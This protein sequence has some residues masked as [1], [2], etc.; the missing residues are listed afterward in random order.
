MRSL[1]IIVSIIA[2]GATA[3]TLVVGKRSFDG[4]VVEKPYESGLDWDKRE[5]QKTALGWRVSLDKNQLKPGMNSLRISVLDKSGKPLPGADVEVTMTRR[6]TNAYDT[7]FHALLQSEGIYMA[8][9]TIPFQGNWQAVI[10]VTSGRDR[11]TFTI[12]LY[13]E[14]G[15]HEDGSPH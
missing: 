6:E 10:A 15:L 7:T 12:P 9:V 4:L 5:Q 8:P 2:L 14:G 13:A 11:S 1:I 3:V